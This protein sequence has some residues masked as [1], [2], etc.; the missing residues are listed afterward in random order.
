MKVNTLM[1]VTFAFIVLGTLAEGY[2]L[3][4]HQEMANTACKSKEQIE[5]VDSKGFECKQ[6]KHII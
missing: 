5:Y 4:H 3:A 2:N 6:D 1:A